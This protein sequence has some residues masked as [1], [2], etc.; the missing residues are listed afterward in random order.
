[1]L[2]VTLW[3]TSF[4]SRGGGG[5]EI[6]LVTSCYRNQDKLRPDGPLGSNAKGIARGGLGVPVT[7]LFSL[8]IHTAFH[9]KTF[10]LM[11]SETRLEQFNLRTNSSWMTAWQSGKYPGCDMGLPPPLW[12]ILATPMNADLPYLFV[13]CSRSLTFIEFVSQLKMTYWHWMGRA[14]PPPPP[15]RNPSSSQKSD[16]YPYPSSDQSMGFIWRPKEIPIFRPETSVFKC[17]C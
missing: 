8:I 12:K 17:D 9:K 13:L 15:P 5:V 7:P 6:L 10:S 16:Q 4:T 1:M 3:W 14:P 11:S 2:G